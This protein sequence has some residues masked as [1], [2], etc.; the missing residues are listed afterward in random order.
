MRPFFPLPWLTAILLAHAGAEPSVRFVRSGASYGEDGAPT[1]AVPLQIERDSEVGETRVRINFRRDFRATP[2]TDFRDDPVELTFADGELVKEVPVSIV[3]DEVVELD[4]SFAAELE[5]LSNGVTGGRESGATVWIRN[6]DQAVIGVTGDGVVEGD[7]GHPRMI[8]RFSMD[9]EVDVPVTGYVGVSGS[10]TRGVDYTVGPQTITL[11]KGDTDFVIDIIPDNLAEP[12][13]WING[14]FQLRNLDASGRDVV[15]RNNVNGFIL[16]Y[17]IIDDDAAPVPVADGPYATLEKTPLTVSQAEGVL[18]NDTDA[19]DGG[20]PENLTA[21]LVSG[22]SRGTI[23]WSGDGGFTYTPSPGFTGT[24][25]FDYAASDG[26]NTS[27]PRTVRIEVRSVVTAAAMEVA[28]AEV[29]Q[30]S[31]QSGLFVGRV[32]VTNHNAGPVP[33]FRLYVAGLPDGMRVFNAQGVRAFGTPP[34]E[35]PYVRH[36]GPLAA[37]ASVTLTVEFFGA[38]RDPGF[39][40]EYWIE[41][42]AEPESPPSAAEAGLAVTRHLPLSNGDQLI[43]IASVP[44]GTY[45][46][47]YSADLADWT[48]VVPMVTATANR[49]QWIDNGPPKTASHPSSVAARYYRFVEIEP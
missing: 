33:A 18:A 39:V 34:V 21:V 16:I 8:W 25:S 29:P 31:R 42:L 3:Q 30:L 38:T 24:D 5:V 26:T 9:K 37:G 40:P 20:G 35:L 45:A 48:R 46:V 32:V 22:P 11:F 17:S 14:A 23:A 13:E 41:L 4:E 6:D 47:E 1:A 28:V 15:L 7:D 2:G 44:G 27:K 43:E 49:L 12:D 19:D 10:A 36:N